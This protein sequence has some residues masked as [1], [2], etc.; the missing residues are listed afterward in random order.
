MHIC[1]ISILNLSNCRCSQ[2]AG[3]NSCS[4]VSGDFSNCSYRLMVLPLTSSHLSSAP[5]SN[6]LEAKN[7]DKL[8]RKSTRRASVHLNQPAT[9]RNRAVTAVTVDRQRPVETATTAVIAATDSAKT[10][11]KQQIKPRQREFIPSR[12]DIWF[13]NY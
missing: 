10:A 7:I 11:K 3:R 12:L 8:S 9:R 13:R 5:A 2:T 1:T 6:F 4:I